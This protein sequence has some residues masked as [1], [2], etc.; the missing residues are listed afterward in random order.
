MGTTGTPMETPGT[1]PTTIVAEKPQ[2]SQPQRIINTFIDPVKTFTDLRRGTAWWMAFIFIAICSYV[3][4]AAVATKIGFEQVNENQMRMN[5]KQMERIDQMPPADRARAMDMGA[6]ITKYISYGFPVVA[7]IVFAITAAILMAIFNFGFGAQVSFGQSLAV[8]VYASLT[9]SLKSLLTAIAL[10]AGAN[11]E[12]FTFEN[13]I[14]S[15][16]GFFVDMNAHPVLYRFASSMDV[17]MIW[18]VVLLGLGYACI[19]KVKRG[20]AIGVVAG[21]WL[22]WVLIATAIK[23]I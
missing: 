23:A 12:N 8:V 5:P 2:L 21:L 15:N 10:F 22:G 6:K 16:L 13:P 4:V 11:P 9:G 17:F 19:S 3:F 18:Y 14:A 1:A 20:T 7:L